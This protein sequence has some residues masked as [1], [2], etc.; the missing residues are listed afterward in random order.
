M[1]FD[2]TGS[3]AQR[4]YIRS[5][6]GCGC[7]W[8]GCSTGYHLLTHLFQ[9]LGL[10][11]KPARMISQRKISLIPRQEQANTPS[12]FCQASDPHLCF[13]LS[14]EWNTVTKA[15]WAQLSLT[16]L[17]WRSAKFNLALPPTSSPL[18]RGLIPHYLYVSHMVITSYKVF[19]LP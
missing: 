5:G 10:T 1:P 3:W 2:F 13:Y 7:L 18:L 14:N 6:A 8:Q 4:Y 17:G 16:S 11:P 9:P 12:W 19:S 15:V